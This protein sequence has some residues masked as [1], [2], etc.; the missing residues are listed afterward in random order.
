MSALEGRRTLTLHRVAA[1]VSS[2]QTASFTARDPEDMPDLGRASTSLCRTTREATTAA[3]PMH[4]ALEW[5]KRSSVG[6]GS[7]RFEV[8]LARW[9][10][11]K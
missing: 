1:L 10:H 9:H 2:T 6:R 11:Y 5:P 4:V 8:G 7:C 3:E